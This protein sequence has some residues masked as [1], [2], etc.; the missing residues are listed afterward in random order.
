MGSISASRVNYS[1]RS[2]DGDPGE[3]KDGLKVSSR[4]PRRGGQVRFRRRRVI[5]DTVIPLP[6][7]RAVRRPRLVYAKSRREIT[8]TPF[9][10]TRYTSRPE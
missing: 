2:D 1:R 5:E 4:S 10:D 6:S 7:A 9:A 3:I 8:A